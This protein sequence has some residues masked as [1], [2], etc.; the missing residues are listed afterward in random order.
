MAE[1]RVEA[2]CGQNVTMTCNITIRDLGGIKLFQWIANNKTCEYRKDHA[3]TKVVCES[4]PGRLSMTVLNVM[5]GDQGNYLCKVRSE[6][7]VKA[8]K[9]VLTIPSVYIFLLFI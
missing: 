8:N 6:T 2:W 9:T 5:P 7:G 1:P 4:E 3:D